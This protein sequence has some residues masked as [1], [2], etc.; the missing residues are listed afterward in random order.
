ALPEVVVVDFRD[1]RAEALLQLRLR[2]L[3]VLP[4]SLQRPRLGEVQLERQDPAVAGAH[5]PVAARARRDVGA[6]RRLSAVS[7]RS[8][9]AASA[10]A[11]PGSSRHSQFPP[12]N[13]P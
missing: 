10:L 8:R 6:R 4:L 11:W 5:Y 7:S 2:R 13:V 9:S 3:D 1:R 12:P